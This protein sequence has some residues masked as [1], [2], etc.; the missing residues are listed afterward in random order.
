LEREYLQGINLE[1]E[2]SGVRETSS[3]RES[4]N[5]GFIS[6][7]PLSVLVSSIQL[8]TPSISHI[9]SYNFISLRTV[10]HINEI[11]GIML[12]NKQPWTVQIPTPL[13]LSLGETTPILG[14]GPKL[15]SIFLGVGDAE[16]LMIIMKPPCTNYARA[17]LLVSR[18]CVSPEPAAFL[19][20]GGEQNPERGGS[21]GAGHWSQGGTLTWLD[22][23]NEGSKQAEAQVRARLDIIFGLVLGFAKQEGRVITQRQVSWG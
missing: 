23:A 12:T 6:E 20:S 16:T 3:E 7:T 14:T 21:P 2:K 15:H 4:S 13:N 8:P 18:A 5:W 11:S 1:R 19:P 22:I 9:K 10:C 17:I